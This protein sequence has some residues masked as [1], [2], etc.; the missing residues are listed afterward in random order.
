[1]KMCVL[2]YP[3]VRPLLS[4]FCWGGGLSRLMPVEG[5][6]RADDNTSEARLRGRLRWLMPPEGAT[7]APTTAW[8]VLFL[9]FD[10]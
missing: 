8:P 9:L 3:K 7:R 4:S 5:A 1:M 10:N 6:T 2:F